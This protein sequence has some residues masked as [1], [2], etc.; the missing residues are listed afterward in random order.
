VN[1]SE[2][3]QHNDEQTQS[4]LRIWKAEHPSTPQFEFR[5]FED[6]SDDYPYPHQMSYVVKGNLHPDFHGL[7]TISKYTYET[8]VRDDL[9]TLNETTTINVVL[10]DTNVLQAEA[11]S[12]GNLLIRV[13]QDFFRFQIGINDKKN[14]ELTWTRFHRKWSKTRDGTDVLHP[15]GL[16]QSILF[17]EV[18]K[19]DLNQLEGTWKKMSNC[20]IL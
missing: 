11:M 20:L 6:I 18:S 13:P 1:S 15:T 12:G 8:I 16:K 7:A 17:D 19:A 10:S 14:L 3:L 5:V 4:T 9:T 2:D